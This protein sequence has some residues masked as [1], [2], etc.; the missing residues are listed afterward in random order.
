MT[1]GITVAL[2]PRASCTRLI[3]VIVVPPALV[4]VPPKFNRRSALDRAVP[5]WLVSTSCPPLLAAAGLP[6]TRA[7]C[8]RALHATQASG[9]P[10]AISLDLVI[11]QSRCD[12]SAD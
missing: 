3:L 2:L 9:T 6:S 5:Q 7:V 12:K 4:I 10:A 8:A 11:V 1:A